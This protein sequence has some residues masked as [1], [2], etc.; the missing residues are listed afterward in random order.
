MSQKLAQT[1][2][3]SAV[4]NKGDQVTELAT[5]TSGPWIARLRAVCKIALRLATK[6]GSPDKWVDLPPVLL[7]PGQQQVR[8]QL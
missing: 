8:E 1:I 4:A 5:M 2:Q 7:V 6:T 3:T